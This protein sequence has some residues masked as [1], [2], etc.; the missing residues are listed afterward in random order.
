MLFTWLGLG[1]VYSVYIQTPQPFL[2]Q[3][4]MGVAVIPQCEN[5]T[6]GMLY[7]SIKKATGERY[8]LIRIPRSS[9]PHL[10]PYGYSWRRRETFPRIAELDFPLGVKTRHPS[11]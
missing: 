8:Q 1:S 2:L 5:R 10:F 9:I 7:C 6:R 11:C 4:I 3:C